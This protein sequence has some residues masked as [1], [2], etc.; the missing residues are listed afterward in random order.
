MKLSI[1]LRT[2]NRL[3]YTIRTIMSI[4]K[5]C[6]LSKDDYEIICIDQ[7]S[8]DGTKEWLASNLR[9]GYYPLRN[10][11]LSENVG[12][13][14]GMQVGIEVAKG[15]FIAQHDNDLE[16]VTPDYFLRLISVYEDLEKEDFNVCAV[17]GSHRQG[18]DIEAKP[19]KFAKLRYPKNFLEGNHLGYIVSWVH[20]SFIFKEKF[21]RLLKFNKGMCNSW[22]STWWDKGYINFNCMN[23][24][25]WHI[26]SGKSGV[27]V[28]KQAE[29]FPNY[30]YVEKNYRKFL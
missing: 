14:R 29:K 4:D 28:K 22:C 16:I 26:D 24:N 27:H 5:N 1:I 9:E 6:G 17:S 23:I 11:L 3:E 7:N 2:W 25:F 8:S 19:H 15:D 18:I 20:G 13:G 30:K 21:T 12:D 10:V